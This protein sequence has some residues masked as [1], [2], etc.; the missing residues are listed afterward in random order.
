[1]KCTHCG[2]LN[3]ATSTQCFNCQATLHV[4]LAPAGHSTKA[5]SPVALM[6]A[7]IQATLID[8]LLM[9]ASAITVVV[10]GVKLAPPRSSAWF[11]GTVVA[12]L[13]ALLLP[14]L[15]DAWGRGSVGKRVMGLRVLKL[16]GQRPG[17]ARSLLRHSAKYLGHLIGPVVLWL[18]EALLL[19]HRKLHEVISGTQVVR[20]DSPSP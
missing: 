10:L 8:L 13:I 2:W 16:H 4:P 18:L 9:L 1:M 15:L 19:R 12:V 6:W 5:E 20:R 14:A 3:P 11:M 17:L 7:R